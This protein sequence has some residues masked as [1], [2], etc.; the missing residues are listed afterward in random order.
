[1]FVKDNIGVR[2]APEIPAVSQALSKSRVLAMSRLD[3]NAPQYLYSWLRPLTMRTEEEGRRGRMWAS[4][5][6][7]LYTSARLR[8]KQISISN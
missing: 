3:E 2:P 8:K 1:M 4:V 6:R 7:L 5:K